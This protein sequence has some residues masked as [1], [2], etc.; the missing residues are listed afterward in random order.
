MPVEPPKTPEKAPFFLESLPGVVRKF[1]K[2]ESIE[3][4][5]SKILNL[6]RVLPESKFSQLLESQNCK[7][8][9]KF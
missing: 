1:V 8:Y 2:R 9:K 5:E 6:S 7:F 3:P 4:N